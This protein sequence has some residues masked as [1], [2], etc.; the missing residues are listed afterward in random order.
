MTK[1]E[2]IANIK[3]KVIVVEILGWKIQ[4]GE[5]FSL[6]NRKCCKID[7]NCINYLKNKQISGT[8]EEYWHIKIDRIV[9]IKK[10]G[11]TFKNSIEERVETWFVEF[12]ESISNSFC[13]NYSQ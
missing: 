6:L 12:A 7:N 13:V 5:N 8:E 10:S 9:W 1:L 3:A 2:Y 4:C 11:K